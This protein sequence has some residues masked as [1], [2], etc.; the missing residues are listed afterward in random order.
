APAA[1]PG[2]APAGLAEAGRGATVALA[3]AAS[4]LN[5]VPT[6]LGEG[7]NIGS[8]SFVVSGQ[9]TASGKPLLA[10]D[11]HLSLSAPGVW[12]QVGLH[13][14]AKRPDCTFDV[15]GFSF[16]GMPGIVIGQNADLAWGLTN[17][18][19]DVMDL[20]LERIY[21]DGT[22]LRDGARVPLEQR[23]ETIDV[24]GGD[25][26][27][28]TVSSTA[29]GPIVSEVLPSTGVAG[30]VPVPEG[31]PPAGFSGYAVALQWTALTPGRTAEAVF[32]L[33]RAATPED[34]AAAAALLEAPAQNILY[35]TARGDIGYQSSGRTPVR[36][37]VPG[38][39]VPSDGSWPRPG[40]DSR[41]DWQGF[42]APQDMPA[43]RNPAAGFIVAANQAVTAAGQG[44]FLT[45]DWD[46]GY[47]AGRIRQLIEQRLDEGKRFDVPA[48]NTIMTDDAS[49]FGPVVVPALLQVDV[50]DDFV[51]QAVDE[52]R[53]WSAE[54]FPTNTDS[55]GAAYFNAVWSA[56]LQLTFADDLPAS[57]APDGGARWLR[58]VQLLLEDPQNPWWDDR[59][60]VNV[61]EGRDEILRQALVSARHQLTNSMGKNPKDWTWGH[62][63]QLRLQHPVLGGATVP[64]PV[65]RLVNPAPIG[66]P[67]GS[68]V[69]NAM[70]YNAAAR[71]E[72]GRP[73][74]SVTAGPSMRMVVD[75]ADRDASTWVAGPG[76][77]GHPGSPHYTDQ[78]R[79]WARGETFPWAF[80]RDAVEQ[81]G[82]E[83]LTLEPAEDR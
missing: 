78:L 72:L 6:L 8:N 17:Q 20:T 14:T 33:N 40:W 42:V 46:E 44:P 65:R 31:A 7:A 12:Y 80:S 21:E 75:L 25:P 48:M 60:T 55:P 1:S 9:H 66:V 32:A 82:T 22:Y 16:S 81:A 27:T 67:G 23:R 26:V 63:H 50:D 29:H 70:S 54:G 39:P 76:N 64:E 58:V 18:G 2:T 71:D 15:A 77:S 53:S 61:V 49:P 5:A 73:D 28:L 41:Y 30:T 59:T 10:N 34:V 74:F 24:N 79:A 35:A 62:V 52:L 68:A 57:Q 37:A 43:V 69:V 45:T 11:P 13:C 38:A 4:A 83:T 19:T 3:H 51:A 36:A 56:L 47:R